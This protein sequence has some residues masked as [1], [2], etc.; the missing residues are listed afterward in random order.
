METPDSVLEEIAEQIKNGYTSG[1]VD[2]D[3][4]YTAWELKTNTWDNT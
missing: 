1:R 4:I 2:D 3:N